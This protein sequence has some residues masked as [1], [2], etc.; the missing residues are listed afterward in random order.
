VDSLTRTLAPCERARAG[1]GATC[2]RGLRTSPALALGG[3][4]NRHRGVTKGSLDQSREA[5]EVVRSA[6]DLSE[7]LSLRD[8][9]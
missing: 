5:Q 4:S 2:R 8:A 3:C 7:Q 9:A 1:W 6:S